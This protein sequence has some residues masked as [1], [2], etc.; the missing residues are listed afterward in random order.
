M[1]CWPITGITDRDKLN[2]VPPPKSSGAG[3]VLIPWST[4]S[5]LVMRRTTAFFLS[6]WRVSARVRMVSTLGRAR[7]SFRAPAAAYDSTFRPAIDPIDFAINSFSSLIHL[8]DITLA[9][10]EYEVG[11]EIVLRLPRAQRNISE[12]QAVTKEETRGLDSSSSRATS[13]Q[14][15]VRIEFSSPESVSQSVVDP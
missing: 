8:R 10:T 3:W 12:L 14:E 4:A 5:C 2:A 1:L 15:S 13:P 7:D 6:A 9:R 11:R